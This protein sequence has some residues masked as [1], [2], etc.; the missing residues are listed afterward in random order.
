MPLTETQ[1][2]KI[3]ELDSIAKQILQHGGEEELLMSLCHK[4]EMIKDIMD[5]SSHA[6]LNL[7]CTEYE[8][9]YRY[10]KLLEQ[11]AEASSKGLFADMPH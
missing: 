5:S 11:M 3:A 1:K 4:M 8:G 9:F 6:E 2:H 7:Y 10:M